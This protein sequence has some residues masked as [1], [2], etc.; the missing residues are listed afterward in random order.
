MSK[1]KTGFK[2]K[3]QVVHKKFGNG[4]VLSSSFSANGKDVYVEVEFDK[5]MKAVPGSE[6]TRRRKISST[7]LEN[8]GGGIEEVDAPA[9]SNSYNFDYNSEETFGDGERDGWSDD[10]D[11]DEELVDEDDDDLD[12]DAEDADE[13]FNDDVEDR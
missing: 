5:A 7:H 12:D 1:Y 6:A 8:L 9:K 11:D 13:D 4:V 2:K 3:D 10:D